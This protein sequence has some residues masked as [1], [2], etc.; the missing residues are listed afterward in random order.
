MSFLE[1]AEFESLDKSVS[2]ASR[3]YPAVAPT[4]NL[5]AILRQL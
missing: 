1:I 2:A 3:I 5:H 4:I